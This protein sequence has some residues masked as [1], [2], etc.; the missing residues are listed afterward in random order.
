MDLSRPVPED[1]TEIL[2]V[3]RVCVFQRQVGDTGDSA[4]AVSGECLLQRLG[5]WTPLKPS[6]RLGITNEKTSPGGTESWQSCPK[7]EVYGLT[8]FAASG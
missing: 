3:L 1:T 6:R 4:M 8:A 2:R 5:L 7:P